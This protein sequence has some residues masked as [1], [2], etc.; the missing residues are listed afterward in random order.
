MTF[1]LPCFNTQGYVPVLLE[2]QCGMFCVELVG[3]W[4]ELDVS[5]G[6]EVF[7]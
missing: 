6:T 1:G 4:V 7:G 3:S 2:N 5:V